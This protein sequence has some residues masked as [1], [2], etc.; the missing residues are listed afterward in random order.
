MSSW[1]DNIG[2]GSLPYKVEACTILNTTYC[3]LSMVE[4]NTKV[5]RESKETL[6]NTTYCPNSLQL[7]SLKESFIL[8]PPE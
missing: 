1:K 2:R 4:N 6:C 7:H 8:Q 5:K 3:Q